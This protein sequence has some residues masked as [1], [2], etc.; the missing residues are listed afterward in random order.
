MED[1]ID[2]R[3]GNTLRT[4]LMPFIKGTS[5]WMVTVCTDMGYRSV[6]RILQPLHKRFHKCI[7]SIARVLMHNVVLPEEAILLEDYCE[8]VGA[9]F[10]CVPS[11]DVD[12]VYQTGRNHPMGLSINIDPFLGCATLLLAQPHHYAIFV[13]FS[14]CFAYVFSF[15]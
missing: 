15:L 12:T 14:C 5:D 6:F 11:Q 1:M 4:G 8:E 9:N 2:Y 3:S 13:L 10:L 7:F